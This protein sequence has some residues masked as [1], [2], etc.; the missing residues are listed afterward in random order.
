MP[1]EKVLIIK[2]SYFSQTKYVFKFR[3]SK[4][5]LTGNLIWTLA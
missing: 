5:V 1:G 4:F 2:L 3:D